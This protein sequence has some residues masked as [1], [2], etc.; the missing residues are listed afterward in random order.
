MRTVVTGPGTLYLGKQGEHLARELAFPETALWA[1]EFGEGRAQLLCRPPGGA[2]AYAVTLEMEEG[3]AVWPVTG[4][5]T[6]WTGYGCCELRWS[7]GDRVVKSRT[8]PT[9]VADALFG[10]YPE[11]KPGGMADHRRLVH[12]EDPDQHPMGAIT[13]LTDAIGKIPPPV[14]AL[15]NLELEALLK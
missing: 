4:A 15:T 2:A 10:G 14:A 11:E 3:A 9:F 12:R 5:D 1:A 6:A 13:G 7:A 8:Y